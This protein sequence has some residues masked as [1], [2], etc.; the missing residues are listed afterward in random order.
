[1]ATQRLRSAPCINY[2]RITYDLL[3]Y[4]LYYYVVGT[5]SERKS[6][7]GPKRT[8]ERIMLLNMA[9]SG[10]KQVQYSIGI[11]GYVKHH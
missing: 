6:E 3:T 7:R 11:M 4:T 5:G 2:S 1:M 10:H 9:I 8:K